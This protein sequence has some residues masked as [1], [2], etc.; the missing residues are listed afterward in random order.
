MKIKITPFNN[1]NPQL[2]INIKIKN[3][4]YC[5]SP[6]CCGLITEVKKSDKWLEQENFW[7]TRS[8]I[9]LVT[10]LRLSQIGD[11]CEGFLVPGLIPI[12]RDYGPAYTTKE[13]EK[14]P[15][16]KDCI[17]LLG[18]FCRFANSDSYSFQ[19]EG[20]EQKIIKLFKSFDYKNNLLIR[21][22]ACLYKAHILLETSFV[23]S[24]EIYVNTYI[25]LE[26]LIEYLKLNL[27]VGRKGV[28]KKI[29]STGV[30]NFEEYEEEMRD[31]IRNDIIHPYRNRYK[32]KI[33]L[34]FMSADDVFE[35]LSFIDWLF[36]QVLLNRIK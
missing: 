22:G 24:E 25:A 31:F 11:E 36:K 19:R 17:G 15:G 29:V 16:R 8:E 13:V 1:K 3:N 2:R 6:A 4:F 28:L 12:I 9:P 26:G 14:F 20:N 23:F 27:N 5:G 10:A 32:Q 18:E 35:D 21:A 30:D 34:P 33:A 7:V